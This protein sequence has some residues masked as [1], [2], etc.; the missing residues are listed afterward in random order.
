MFFDSHA[1]LT[2]D[3]LFEDLAGVLERAQKAGVY[4]I[5]NICTDS[6][7]LERALLLNE[8]WIYRAGATTPHDVEKEG[9]RYFALFKEAA[10]TGKLQA[11]GETGLDYYYKELNRKVQQK[12]LERYTELAME[13]KLPLIFHCREAFEDLYAITKG[14]PGKAVMHCFTGSMHEA[15]EAI[16]RGWMLSFSGILTFKKS[17]ALREVAS[18]VP[19]NQVLVETDSPYLAP[20]RRRGK[21]CEPAYVIET[22]QVLALIRGLELEK[23]AQVTCDNGE[24]VFKS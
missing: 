21:V 2:Y 15:E 18:E 20:E 5:V 23:M 1:H 19:L 12:F 24:R 7:T 3:P 17:E 16:E 9:E 14:F 4:R 6:I 10:L 13:A 8:P 11:I 22:C